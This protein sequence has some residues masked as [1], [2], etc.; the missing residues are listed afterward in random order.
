MRQNNVFLSSDRI[1]LDA[2]VQTMRGSVESWNVS[3]NCLT[4]S[5]GTTK[6]ENLKHHLSQEEKGECNYRDC[7][8]PTV[9]HPNTS[10][11]GG[12]F[13]FKGMGLLTILNK[14]SD[15]SQECHQNI[16]NELLLFNN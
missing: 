8:V 4:A 12:W 13:S 14:D 5:L 3:K 10:G 11:V 6:I 1:I 2:G 9:N 16:L 7:A 15:R